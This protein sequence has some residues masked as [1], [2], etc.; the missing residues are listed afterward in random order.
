MVGDAGVER[1]GWNGMDDGGVV[2]LLLVALAVRVDQQGDQTA[3]NGAAEPH[4]NHVE[5][6]EVWKESERLRVMP[7]HMAEAQL[8]QQFIR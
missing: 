2:R 7:I 8:K 6:V 5:E 3:K 4:S 1:R